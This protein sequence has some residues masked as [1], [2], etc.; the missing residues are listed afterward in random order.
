MYIFATNKQELSMDIFWE[1]RLDALG[2][3]NNPAPKKCKKLSFSKM[4]YLFLFFYQR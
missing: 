1:I 3:F 2:Y 4:P